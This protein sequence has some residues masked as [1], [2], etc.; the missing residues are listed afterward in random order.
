MVPG[1]IR[2]R[3][4]ASG[5]AGDPVRAMT[6]AASPRGMSRALGLAELRRDAATVITGRKLGR[7]PNVNGTRGVSCVEDDHATRAIR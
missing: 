1:R 2:V 6:L 3:G 7:R 5:E 4:V